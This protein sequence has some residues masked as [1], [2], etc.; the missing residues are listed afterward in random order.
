MCGRPQEWAG[1]GVGTEARRGAGTSRLGKRKQQRPLVVP[2][3]AAGGREVV[4]CDE[5]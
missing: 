3:S 5:P 1:K 2:R 4:T